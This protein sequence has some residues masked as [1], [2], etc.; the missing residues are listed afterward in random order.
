MK[1]AESGGVLGAQELDVEL[2]VLHLLRQRQHALSG[3]R[4]Q[5]PF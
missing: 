4:S 2:G 5:P 1:C 3:P